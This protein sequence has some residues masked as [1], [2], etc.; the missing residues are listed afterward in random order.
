MQVGHDGGQI[1]V[2]RDEIIRHVARMRSDV[3]QPGETQFAQGFEQMSERTLLVPIVHAVPRVH[4]LPQK[5][6]LAHARIDKR[7]GLVQNP[8]HGARDFRPARVGHH[9]KRAELVASLLH[10]QKRRHAPCT[11]LR[12][13]ARGQAV[14]L[15]FDRI[16]RIDHRSRRAASHHVGQA[17]I[18]L[19]ADH[20]IDHGRAADDLRALGLRHATRNADAHGTPFARALLLHHAQAT[21][22]GI[23]LLGRLFADMAGVQDDEIGVLDAVGARVAGRAKAFGH[24]VPVIDVHLAAIGLD[25]NA[26]GAGREGRSG[27][28]LACRPARRL[29]LDPDRRRAH[30]LVAPAMARPASGGASMRLIGAGSTLAPGAD[31]SRPSAM[32]REK[33]CRTRSSNWAAKRLRSMLGG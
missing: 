29:P 27:R 33:A 12:R 32:R 28:C 15:R 10:A 13:V 24:A 7:A 4:V 19:R 26:L 22:F 2:S 17:M 30:S 11:N 16:L 1:A 6:D 8:R 25:V 23:H 31:G 21:E 3:A 14:E 20:P 18:G 9:A 5:R